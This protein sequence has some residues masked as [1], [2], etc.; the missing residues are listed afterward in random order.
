MTN[1]FRINPRAAAFALSALA[2]V[3]AAN[4]VRA[5]AN[6]TAMAIGNAVG[7]MAAQEQAAR[8]EAACRAGVPASP[9]VTAKMTARM[10]RVMDAYF[11]LNAKSGAYA[12]GRVFAMKT[13]GVTWKDETGSVALDQLGDRLTPPATAPVLT[14]SV[15]GGDGGSGRAIWRPADTATATGSRIYAVDFTSEGHMFDYA[16]GVRILHM[17]VLPASAAPRAPGAFCHLDSQHGF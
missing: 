17:S 3:T 9:N 2:V 16:V 15:V 14:D 7:Q 6:Y 10:Q 12:L 8:E 4:P 5:Q 13:D 1:Q 11:A